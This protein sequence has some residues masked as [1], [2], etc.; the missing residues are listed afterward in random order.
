[1]RNQFLTGE[2]TR[3]SECRSEPEKE[4]PI[5]K[6]AAYELEAGPDRTS[7]AGV[8]FHDWRLHR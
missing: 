3:G 5:V 6:K 2:K 7:G 8:G 1:M 4:A